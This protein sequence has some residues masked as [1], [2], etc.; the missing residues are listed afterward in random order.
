MINI[1]EADLNEFK[2]VYELIS[3]EFISADIK[4]YDTVYKLVRS[5]ELK[6]YVIEEEI[7]YGGLFL[8]IY[9]DIVFIENLAIS[10]KYHSS[11]YG[12]K[13]LGAILDKYHDKNMVLEVEEDEMLEKRVNFYERLGFKIYRNNYYYLPKINEETN[14]NKMYLM[15]TKLI[16]DDN[17]FNRMNKI[18]FENAYNVKM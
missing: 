8:S 9:D 18:I 5:E 10:S 7:I 3:A 6:V 1:R 14:K 4:P 2:E 17:E 15:S 11:G 12:S 16:E 13:F